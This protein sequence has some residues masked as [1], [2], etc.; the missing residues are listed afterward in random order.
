MG[1]IKVI[2]RAPKEPKA[3]K[4]TKVYSL[5]EPD[6]TDKRLM[7]VIRQA[8]R[9]LWSRLPVR[10]RALARA[11]VGEKMWKCE[12]CGN[13]VSNPEVDHID[14][15]GSLLS[16]ADLPEFC[17]RLFKVT[18]EGVNVLCKPCHGQKTREDNEKRRQRMKDVL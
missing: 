13:I 14:D 1:D 2:P 15:A 3:D 5:R 12:K 11:Q 7:S 6:W 9:S 10:M 16:F 8:M 4:P 17:E 18:E